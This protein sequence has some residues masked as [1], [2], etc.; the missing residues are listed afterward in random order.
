MNTKKHIIKLTNQNKYI[1]EE[2]EKIPSD[3]YK[4]EVKY[5]AKIE[6]TI[7]DTSNH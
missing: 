1:I 4:H 2:L 7:N 6:S 3:Q 5:G